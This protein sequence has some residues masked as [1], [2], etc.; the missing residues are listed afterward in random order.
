MPASRPDRRSRMPLL[1]QSSPVGLRV[2]IV[3]YRAA[4]SAVPRRALG[5]CS[6]CPQPVST[7]LW[8]AH[9][10]AREASR[11]RPDAKDVSREMTSRILVVDDDTALAEMIGI[12]LRTEGF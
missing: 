7:T 8:G 11:P 12:V 1:V 3:S 9:G 6:A 4:A 2:P 5:R 10:D